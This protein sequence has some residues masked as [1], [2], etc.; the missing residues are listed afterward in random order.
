MLFDA[1]LY[2]QSSISSRFS[3]RAKVLPGMV[4]PVDRLTT[5][6]YVRILVLWT[7]YDLRRNIGHERSGVI[8]R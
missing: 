8:L 1:I 5:E 6:G 7:D 4:D 3:P 2:V